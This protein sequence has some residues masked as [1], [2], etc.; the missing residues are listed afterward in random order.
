MTSGGAGA[1]VS[2]KGRGGRG[3]KEPGTG[4]AGRQAHQMRA[5]VQAEGSERGRDG[6]RGR[7]CCCCC[8]KWGSAK[9]AGR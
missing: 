4:W 5:R 6:C 7:C 8:K 3:R 1:E 9:P 2:Y